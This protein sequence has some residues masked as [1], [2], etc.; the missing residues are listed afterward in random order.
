MDTIYGYLEEA[1]DELAEVWAD[2][3]AFDDE[4]LVEHRDIMFERVDKAM[5]YLVY[6]EEELK[7][8]FGKVEFKNS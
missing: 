8:K 4:Q 6:L 2:Y 7:A 5:L 1:H 3:E